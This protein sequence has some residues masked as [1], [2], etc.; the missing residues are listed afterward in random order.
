[1]TGLVFLASALRGSGLELSE[2]PEHGAVSFGH[3]GDHGSWEVFCRARDPHSQIAVYSLHPR[4]VEP[5][6][7]TTMMELITRANF[8]LIIDNFELDLDDGELRFKTSLDFS[9]YRL[10]GP[11][12]AQLI[13]HNLDAFDRYLPALDAVMTGGVK[14]DILLER[15]ES[16]A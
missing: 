4:A 11:L 10:S 6:H 13:E 1:M 2:H 14:V 8:G 5:T 3:R 12:I 9:N 16:T 15:V 7:R